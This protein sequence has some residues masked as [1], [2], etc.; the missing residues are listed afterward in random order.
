MTRYAVDKVLWQYARDPE[1]RA[2]FERDRA[3]VLSGRELDEAERGALVAGDVREIFR[4]G[5]HPFLLYSYAIAASGGW[6]FAMMRDYVAKL[7]GL[8]AGDIET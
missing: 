3:G 8:E 2:E 1:F 6:S 7:E 5:A 4:L